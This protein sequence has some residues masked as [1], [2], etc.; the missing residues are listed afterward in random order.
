MSLGLAL[1]LRNVPVRLHEAG[2]YPRHRVCGEFISGVTRETLD[3]LGIADI[4]AEAAPRQTLLWRDSSGPTWRAALP[5]P[6]LAISRHRLDERLRQRFTQLGGILHTATRDRPTPAEGRVWAAGRRPRPGPWVGLKAHFR[7]E[8][9]ADLE[10]HTGPNGYLGLVRV[11]EGWTNVCGLF[12]IGTAPAAKGP[13]LLISHIAA[14]AHTALADRLRKAE[15]RQD[16]FCAVAGFGL[17]RQQ[18]TPGLLCIGDAESI[19]PPFTGHG[20]S[21]ALQAAESAV[22]P[23]EMWSTGQA[24][25]TQTTNHIR[26]LLHHRFRR[27]LAAARLLHPWLFQPETCAALSGLASSGLLPFRSLL[28]WLR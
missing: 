18:E 20:M 12:R 7:L 9:S 21:M 25:W 5:E 27:R 24:D 6:A 11:E 13:D 10:M 4:L 23:L 8:T 28:A 1:R 14:G 26:H 15:W 2:Q 19:I 16:S 17:G 22:K 3:R